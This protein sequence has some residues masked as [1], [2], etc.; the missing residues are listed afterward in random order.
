[1]GEGCGHLRGAMILPIRYTVTDARN[2]YAT[3]FYRISKEIRKGQRE[4]QTF[5][6][7]PVKIQLAQTFESKQGDK[8]IEW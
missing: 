8:E 1:M 3:V 6:N 2:Y 4:N 7:N 5:Q